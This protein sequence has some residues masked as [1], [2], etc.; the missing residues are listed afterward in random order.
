[1][2]VSDLMHTDVRA[3]RSDA[4]L[5]GVVEALADAHI[6][7]VPVVDRRGKLLGVVS[8]TDILQAQAERLEGGENWEDQLVEDVMTRPPLT[9][10]ADADIREAA[11]R[12]L[13]AE[14]HR[15]FIEK[16]GA[17]AGVISQTDIVRALATHQ[18]AG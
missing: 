15:L 4:T 6:S 8:T 9:I 1:M 2:K 3:V 12:M 17:L 5:A 7:G 18:V 14:V 11:Q 10:P 13:Y 16:N